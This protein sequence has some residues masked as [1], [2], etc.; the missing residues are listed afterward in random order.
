MDPHVELMSRDIAARDAAR[1]EEKEWRE[2]YEMATEYHSSYTNGHRLTFGH[3]TFTVDAIKVVPA[4]Q[5]K[6][7]VMGVLKQSQL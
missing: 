7:Y 3:I 4:G 5:R 1:E 2:I 6:Q